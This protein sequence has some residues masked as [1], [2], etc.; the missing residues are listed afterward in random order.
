MDQGSPSS[1][2]SAKDQGGVARSVQSKAQEILQEDYQQARALVGNAAKSK[3]YLYPIKGIAYFATNKS[4]W[5]PFL[6]C[7]GPYF[8]LSVG[9]TTGM[10]AFT[11]VPQLTVLVLFNGPLAVFT[12]VLLVLNESA[13]LINVISRN[14]LLQDALLDTFDGTLVSK[15]ADSIV[16]EGRQLQ[17]GTDPMQKLGRILKSPFE[18]FSPKA[19]IRY[20][21]YLPLNF[22]PLVG[23]ALFV[24]IQAR[25]RGQHVHGRWSASQSQD[26]LKRHSG[27]YTA[28]GLVATGLEMIPFASMFFSFSN[29]V[30]A[31]LWAAD[32]ETKD[33]SMTDGTAPNL[34]ETAKKA[35]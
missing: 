22:I 25:A 20:V 14:W 7:I 35:D 32:M 34:R 3:A 26:W 30:G 11:Y 8:L 2:S 21:M 6:S 23:S 12:T 27:P 13:T 24:L 5:G 33:T 17:P 1:S 9:V 16:R 10:F 29:T 18:R 19:L 15:N 28:F 31:A 4:L